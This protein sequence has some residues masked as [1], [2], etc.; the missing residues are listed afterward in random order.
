[1]NDYVVCNNCLTEQIVPKGSDYCLY[2]QEKGCLEEGTVKG[3]TFD[4][5]EVEQE[6]RIIQQIKS[7]HSEN[8]TLE[9]QNYV[10]VQQLNMSAKEYEK[11]PMVFSISWSIYRYL[12]QQNYTFKDIHDKYDLFGYNKK[13]FQKLWGK[14]SFCCNSNYYYYVWA[15]KVTIKEL[16]QNPY[17]M[18]SVYFVLTAKEKGTCIE[19]KLSQSNSE[20]LNNKDITFLN[21]LLTEL[22]R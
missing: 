14:Q 10:F 21:W 20:F 19:K 13:R 1:M 12:K 3:L 17:Y 7:D 4:T 22:A 11:E 16:V 8:I 9:N 15:F 18:P 2:C 6:P 5:T